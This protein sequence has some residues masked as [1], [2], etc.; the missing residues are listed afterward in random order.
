MSDFPDCDMV[1]LRGGP[2]DG[3]SIPITKNINMV[4]FYIAGGGLITYRR[5]IPAQYS[6]ELAIFQLSEA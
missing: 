6:G 2:N 5:T 1:M 4:E 3:V